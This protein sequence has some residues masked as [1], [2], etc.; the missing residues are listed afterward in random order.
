MFELPK[1]YLQ[2]QHDSVSPLLKDIDS[3]KVRKSD[4]SKVIDSK[5]AKSFPETLKDALKS[6]IKMI[7]E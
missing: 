6:E 5:E 3:L 1:L 4:L 2:A 7:D